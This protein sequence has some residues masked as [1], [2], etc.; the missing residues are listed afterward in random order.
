MMDDNTQKFVHYGKHKTSET[1]NLDVEMHT[2][3]DKKEL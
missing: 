2:Y 3:V 1:I